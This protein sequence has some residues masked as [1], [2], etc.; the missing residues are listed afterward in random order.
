[1]RLEASRR[2]GGRAPP[3]ARGA[4]RPSGRRRP[5]SS[6]PRARSARDGDRR[7]R[8]QAE[9]DPGVLDVMDRER[10]GH[11]APRRAR[12]G[13]T[14]GFVSW[15]AA[16]RPARPRRAPNHCGARAPERALDHRDRRQRLRASTRP[17]RRAPAAQGSVNRAPPLRLSVDALSCDGSASQALGADFL[18]AR[19]SR[20]RMSPPRS[21]T[22]APSIA[23][24]RCSAFSSSV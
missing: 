18:T 11:V 17:G 13:Q 19:P 4:A 15:S 9:G 20:C 10:P 14:R 3:A 16:M 23:L 8:E 1:M 12:A 2:S 5:A 22:R 21:A 7:A 6:P 24:N